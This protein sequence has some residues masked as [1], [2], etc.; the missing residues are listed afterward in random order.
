MQVKDHRIYVAREILHQG[1]LMHPFVIKF[2]SVFLTAKHI[3]VSMEYAAG[4]DLFKYVRSQGNRIPEK[5]ARYFFQQ[6][7]IGLQY[8]HRRVCDFVLVY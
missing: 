7:I 5:L 8:V 2:Y 1:S 4:G 3:A 6:L